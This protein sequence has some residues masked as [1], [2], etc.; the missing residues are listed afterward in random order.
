LKR[1]GPVSARDIAAHALGRVWQEAAFASAALDVELSR[2]QVEPR[3]AALATEL[4]YGVLRVEPA[5]LARLKAVSEKFRPPSGLVRAHL[6]IGAYAICFLD[7]VPAFA[8]VSEAVE[9]TRR[10]AGE[11]VGGFVNAVLRKLAADVEK[12]GRPAIADAVLETCPKWLKKALARAIGAGDVQRYL[13]EGAFPPPLGLCLANGLDRDAMIERFEF[14]APFG[15][16][17]KGPASPRAVLVKGAGDLRKLPGYGLD[18]ITQEEGAQVVALALGARPGE[19]VLDACAGHGNKAWVLAQ[20][21]GAEGAADAADLH[22]LK[23]RALEKA[24]DRGA[25]TIGPRAAPSPELAPSPAR[26]SGRTTRTFVVDWSTGRGEVPLGYDRALIDAPC[27]GT[28]TLRRRP[29][30]VLRRTAED[31]AR[32]A[33]LQL[34]I[35]RNA[36]ACVRDGGRLVYAVCSALREEA[37]DV[38]A[39]ALAAGAADGAKLAPA[40]FDSPLI[41]ALFGDTAAFRLLPHVHGTDG[42]FAASFVVSREHETA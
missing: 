12:K 7:R 23:L 40:P 9:A 27:S 41:Q 25:V 32:L 37:E 2:A 29:E 1:T 6:L 11:K 21:V 3:E 4:C 20:V 38:V 8:A 42:Y 34:A 31:V 10:V 13:T 19:R 14:A 28:G 17:T 22:A 39:A 18:F 33:E 16:F 26:P 24:V 30:I 5:L 36:A 15:S 35:V